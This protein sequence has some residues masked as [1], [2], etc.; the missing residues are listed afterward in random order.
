MKPKGP[1]VRAV[2]YCRVSKEQARTS[3]VTLEA[4]E[5]RLRAYCLSLGLEV[6]AVVK[7]DGVSG[8]VPFAERPAGAQV[9]ELFLAGACNLTKGQRRG[10][11]SHLVAAKLDR[12][13]RDTADLLSTVRE[14]QGAGVAVH[15]SD[16]GGLVESLENDDAE[17]LLTIRAAFASHE[18]RK[19]STRTKAALS[20]KKSQGL[21]VGKIPLGMRLASDGKHLEPDPVTE[22]AVRIMVENR[23]E[24]L[25]VREEMALCESRAAAFAQALKETSQELA[26][27]S[28]TRALYG[29][30]PMDEFG[31]EMEGYEA[32]LVEYEAK[33]E[34]KLRQLRSDLREHR[35]LRAELVAKKKATSILA[36]VR[37]LNADPVAY[38]PRGARPWNATTIR[39]ALERRP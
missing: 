29:H 30:G 14:Y 9:R 23:R 24:E 7:D 2:L 19:I 26:T 18:R 1:T 15:T 38:P 27:I 34:A 36:T 39:Q 16:E 37:A 25:R 12:F 28:E 35:K 22:R 11:P 21:R 8:A 10:A 33:L 20:F 13:G 5:S 32:T 6:A 3:G 31:E 17:L 4:Q